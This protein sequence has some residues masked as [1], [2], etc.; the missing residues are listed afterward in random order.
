M[1]KCEWHLID[2]ARRACFQPATE[3]KGLP[4]VYSEHRK[5]ALCEE[6]VFECARFADRR[7]TVTV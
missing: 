6:H 3:S 2:A 1:T 4:E 7:Y 5:V